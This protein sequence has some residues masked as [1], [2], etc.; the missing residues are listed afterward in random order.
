M[1]AR[2]NHTIVYSSD[3]TKSARFLATIL[4]LSAPKRQPVSAN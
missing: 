4:G 2:L 1:T 3:R